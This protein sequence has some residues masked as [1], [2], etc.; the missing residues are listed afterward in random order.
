MLVDLL[1]ANA[2]VM[3]GFAIRN[4]APVPSTAQGRSNLLGFLELGQSL[5]HSVQR[6]ARLS[7]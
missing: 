2:S 1:A 4:L 6:L 7:T 5:G 3:A